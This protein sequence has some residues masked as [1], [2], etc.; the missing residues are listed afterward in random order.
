MRSLGFLEVSDD[1]GSVLGVWNSS[2]SHSV[3]WSV[4]SWGLEVLVEGLLGPFS[5]AGKSTRVSE[6]FS[7]GSWLFAENSTELWSSTVGC[8]SVAHSALGLESLLSFG[9]ISSCLLLWGD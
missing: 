9:S 7:I 3:S 1:I 2:E 5:L 6:T 8:E 4:I